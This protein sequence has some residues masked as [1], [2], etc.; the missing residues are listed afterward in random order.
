MARYERTVLMAYNGWVP[1]Q[2]RNELDVGTVLGAFFLN[3]KHY[4]MTV[5]EKIDQFIK[6]EGNG[7]I[8]DALNVALA[9]L[10]QKQLEIEAQNLKIKL[11]ED[12]IE[13]LEADIEMIGAGF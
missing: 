4:N 3:S 8:R 6:N 11:L 10:D 9:R 1:T 12:K 7:N 13:Q 2:A 5:T